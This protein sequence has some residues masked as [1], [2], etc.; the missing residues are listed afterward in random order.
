[1]GY[2]YGM[3]FMD[4]A[5]IQVFVCFTLLL[6]SQNDCVYKLTLPAGSL[7]FDRCRNNFFFTDISLNEE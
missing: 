2:Y 3:D 6:P 5:K 4:A 1:M 7:L